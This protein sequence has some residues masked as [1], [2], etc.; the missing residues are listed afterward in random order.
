MILCRQM[1]GAFAH[2]SN[3]VDVLP[4]NVRYGAVRSEI[5]VFEIV[6]IIN[7][8]VILIY[9]ISWTK[10][11]FPQDGI[12]V[13]SQFQWRILSMFHRKMYELLRYIIRDMVLSARRVKFSR[14]L[15]L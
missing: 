13:F 14:L 7:I 12:R 6:D 9:L 2:N 15:I 1:G 5:K 10:E 4:Q 3:G 11:N 8:L